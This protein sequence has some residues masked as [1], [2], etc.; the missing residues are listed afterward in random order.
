MVAMPETAM[1]LPQPGEALVKVEAFSVN[2]G[3]IFLL[4]DPRPGHGPARTSRSRH[5]PP[6]SL[7]EGADA[8]EQHSAIELAPATD[9]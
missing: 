7:E 2:R 6:L 1:P 9:H 3:E 5:C 4:E 8:T